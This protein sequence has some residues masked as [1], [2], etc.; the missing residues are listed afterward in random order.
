VHQRQKA[1]ER[2]AVGWQKPDLKLYS[3]VFAKR[4]GVIE[5]SFSS[6]LDWRGH[7]EDTENEREIVQ[8]TD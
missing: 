8:P 5:N 6:L 7:T 2:A 1:W 4:R 3:P